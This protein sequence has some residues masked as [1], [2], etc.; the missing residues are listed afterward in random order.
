MHDGVSISELGIDQ[1]TLIQPPVQNHESEA[2]ALEPRSSVLLTRL[3]QLVLDKPD[4]YSPETR[5]NVWQFIHQ[6][7]LQ[8]GKRVMLLKWDNYFKGID[9]FR[10]FYQLN[11]EWNHLNTSQIK[12]IRV[13]I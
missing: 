11:S 10:L 8:E 13:I 1:A 12:K 7:K 5:S 6:I 2:V 4:A 9:D 3:D